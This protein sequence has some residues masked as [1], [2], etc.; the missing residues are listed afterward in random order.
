MKPSG[1]KT[2]AR[3]V[4]R[5]GD[6]NRPSS[7]TLARRLGS[8]TTRP[9]DP[10]SPEIRNR[11]PRRHTVGAGGSNIL[12]GDG[13]PA[14]GPEAHDEFRKALGVAHLPKLVTQRIVF[15]DKGTKTGEVIARHRF[16]CR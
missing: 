6:T 12:G 8:E 1:R 7:A 11:K 2:R 13:Q 10:A 16:G 14:L 3:S 15:V 9:I 5:R 4:R